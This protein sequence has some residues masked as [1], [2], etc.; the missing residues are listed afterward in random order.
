MTIL[1]TTAAS[2]RAIERYGASLK[3]DEGDEESMV[4]LAKT[5]LKRSA[6]GFD[7]KALLKALSTLENGGLLY[8]SVL[9]LLQQ[10]LRSKGHL[11]GYRFRTIQSIRVRSERSP[12]AKKN[13]VLACK[14][15]PFYF[16]RVSCCNV[17]LAVCSSS[18]TCG[19]MFG[20]NELEQCERLCETA[21][22]VSDRKGEDASM[23]LAEVNELHWEA[24]LK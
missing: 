7:I 19:L 18:L 21:L 10:L 15:M 20:R 17:P 22:R 23:I 24:H 9:L 14:E 6:T 1:A 16:C 12:G 8:P 2:C 11:R 5:H 4:G 13:H 3:E